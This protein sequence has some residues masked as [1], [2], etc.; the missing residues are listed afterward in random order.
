M[1]RHFKIIILR[2]IRYRD[3]I[4]L[5]AVPNHFNAANKWIT[6]MRKLATYFKIVADEVMHND[7]GSVKLLR[8]LASNIVLRGN[9]GRLTI[10]PHIKAEGAPL[11]HF[12]A[13]H[14][15]VRSWPVTEFKRIINQSPNK[16]A[17]NK[18]LQKLRKWLQADP[19][20][21]KQW[22]NSARFPQPK[23]SRASADTMWCV[24]PWHPSYAVDNPVTRA[25]QELRSYNHLVREAFGKDFMIQVSWKNAVKS[26]Y[27][28]FNLQAKSNPA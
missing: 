27:R 19:T 10:E 5:S 6:A 28:R 24:L 15:S 12:S 17:E 18:A 9:N 4:L 22:E 20:D 26:N 8:Y 7:P 21:S 2:Y 1:N 3:D 14:P 13:H 25:L 11:N 23:G 16:N